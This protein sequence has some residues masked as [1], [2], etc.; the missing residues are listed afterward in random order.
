MYVHVPKDPTKHSKEQN[1][2]D[3]Q[4]KLSPQDSLEKTSVLQDCRALTFA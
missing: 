2:S 4:S 1:F 3:S